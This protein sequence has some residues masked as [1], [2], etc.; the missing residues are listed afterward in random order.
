MFLQEFLFIYFVYNIYFI[1]L[2][3]LEN[4]KKWN[5]YNEVFDKYTQGSLMFNYIKLF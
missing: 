1:Q 5:I 3:M 4:W 2:I